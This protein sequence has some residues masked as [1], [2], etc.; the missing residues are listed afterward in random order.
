MNILKNIC[1]EKCLC[2]APLILLQQQAERQWKKLKNML[3]HKEQTTTNEN[4]RKQVDTRKNKTGAYI[5]R[6]TACISLICMQS[7]W[8]R[9]YAP[10][11]NGLAQD[12][13]SA[14]GFS[15]KRQHFAFLQRKANILPSELSFRSI[16]IN[17]AVL[18][19]DRTCHKT[20][21]IV[22]AQIFPETHIRSIKRT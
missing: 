6:T 12:T 10:F 5:R 21:P 11:D 9:F 22:T 8:P 2:G 1:L 13:F 18:L 16:M 3:N 20:D 17:L 7:D 19:P 14:A 15:H 4:M